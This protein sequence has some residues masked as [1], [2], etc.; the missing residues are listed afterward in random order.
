MKI[1]LIVAI[2][3]LAAAAAFIGLNRPAKALG[4][5]DTAPDFTADSALDGKIVPFS[6]QDALAKHAV[7]L[8]FF[9][10]AFTQG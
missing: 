8:Y 7:V 6:L 3:V 2:A 10:K 9:P 1:V 4:V 5:G